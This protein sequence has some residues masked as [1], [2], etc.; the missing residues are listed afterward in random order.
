[1]SYYDY[2]EDY[3]I[4]EDYD[5]D[6]GSKK[7]GKG[8]LIAIILGAVLAIAAVVGVF[9]V[10]FKDKNEAVATSSFIQ[11]GLVMYEEPELRLGDPQG[12]RFKAT[13]SP[14]LKKEV[15]S[16]EN[17]CFGFVIAPLTYFVQ[18]DVGNDFGG[19]DWLKTF[20]KE[21]MAVI[22]VDECAVVTKSQ[23]DGTITEHLIQGSITSILY[24]NGRGRSKLQICKLSRRSFI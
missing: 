14:E 5:Y 4:F 13:V 17:K 6:G 24:N 15:E 16:D 1:M 8:K 2:D 18:V 21:G 19:I 20:E 7:K 9:A 11:E 22:T 3:D 10:V 12:I 23:A